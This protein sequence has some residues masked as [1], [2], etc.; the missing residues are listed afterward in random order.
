MT[1]A[2]SVPSPRSTLRRAWAI[3]RP[4]SIT[5]LLM[6]GTI[7]AATIGLVADPR[8]ITGAPAWLKPMKFAISITIY[9][10]TF[11]WL[12][13]FLRGRLARIAAWVTVIA[14]L[15]EMALIVVQ[16]IRGTTSHFNVSSPFNGAVWSLMAFSIIC[17]WL[18]ALV[19]AILL[20]RRRLTD[21][22]LTWAVRFGVLIGLV[23]MAVAFFMTSPT[24]Q[25]LTAAKAGQGLP[26]SGAHTVG[27][28][29][30]GAG[31]PVVGWSTV[32]GDL[33]APHFIGLHALQLLP[34][35]GWLLLR[36]GKRLAGGTRAALVV[37]AGLCYLGIVGILTWQAL[38]GQSIIH[39]DAATTAAAGAL[40]AVTVGAILVTLLRT[41]RRA[42]AIQANSA[43]QAA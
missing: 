29:D 1:L 25:Q 9:A 7:L 24:A 34:L 33:R 22:G 3:N 40:L 23:G 30:G 19:T 32:G 41:P 16:V 2:F 39:P 27:F 6:L 15:V 17:L 5:I 4:L 18:A 36:Y 11:I 42:A 38:R 31:L 28:P 21:P 26:I 35:I 37:I 14:L 10:A 13:S 8:V 20:M 43:S 12:L